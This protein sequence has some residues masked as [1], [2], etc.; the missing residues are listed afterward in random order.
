MRA[1]RSDEINRFPL[2]EP[3]E[4]HH[5]AKRWRETGDRAAA[6]RIITSHLRLVVK[7]AT[8]Y[9]GYG[10]PTVELVAEGNLGLIRAV[11]HFDPDRGVRFSTYAT[12]W[13]RARIQEYILRSWSMV[14]IGTTASQ[15][16][17]FFNLRK[18]KSRLSAVHEGDLRPH[19]V[20]SIAMQLGVNERDVIDMDHRIHGD[21]SLNVAV[22]APGNTG[23]W[24]DWLIDDQID[25]ERRVIETFEM[26][27]RHLALLQ[28]LSVLNSRERR[29]LEARRLA[30]RPAKL[31][32]LAG[33]LGISC[34][35]VRQIEVRAFEKLRRAV[36]SRIAE[37]ERPSRGGL[38]LQSGRH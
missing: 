33:E 25:Q 12:W 19:E 20:K 36:V 7:I 13:I 21:L 27:N 5:L 23:E 15:R 28:S 26:S 22:G 29:I 11:D 16:R 17:I 38:R 9:R 35:R 37:I 3:L 6:H 34:E 8:G 1:Y 10:F 30:E 2:L 24:Q 14:R 31:E 4:E 32:E 18:L